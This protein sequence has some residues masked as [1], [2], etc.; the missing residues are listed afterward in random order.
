MTISI[1]IE[2]CCAERNIYTAVLIVIKLN[3]VVLNVVA[4]EK[5]VENA[6]C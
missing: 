3:V 1:R 6:T 5:S 2:F 4:P